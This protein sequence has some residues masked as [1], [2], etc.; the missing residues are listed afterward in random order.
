[1]LPSSNIEIN[2]HTLVNRNSF[3][4]LFLFGLCVQGLFSHY[5]KETREGRILLIP[6]LINFSKRYG[7]D[8]E[9]DLKDK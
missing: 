4:L 8:Y 1:M 7:G 5:V 9:S 3:L 6:L 2:C